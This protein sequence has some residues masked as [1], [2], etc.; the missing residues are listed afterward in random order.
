MRLW[1][2][3]LLFL[4]VVPVLLLLTYG[5]GTD[6]KVI[7]SPLVQRQAPEFTLP[8]F[9][10]GTVRLADL[11]GKIVVLNFWASWCYPSCWNEA[12]RLQATWDRHRDQEVMVVGVNYQDKEADARAFLKR[13][14]KTYPNGPDT[15]SRISIDYG[16]YGV[17]ETFFID[18]GGRIAHK[19]I[20]EI[21][22]AVLHQWI[23][24]LL[25]PRPGGPDA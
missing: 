4:T 20:G 13:F 17:P 14:G 11:R 23:T 21:N 2:K 18:P 9:D 15:G 19:H 25:S 16:V 8:L 24:K 6:P 5:L 10:G 7:P 3:L 22:S 1:K 12:P